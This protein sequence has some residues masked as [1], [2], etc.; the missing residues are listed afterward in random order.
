[1]KIQHSASDS[2]LYVDDYVWYG[3]TET[4]YIDTVQAA[5]GNVIFEDEYSSTTKIRVLWDVNSITDGWME[6]WITLRQK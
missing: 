2:G 6:A 3:N 5:Y 4:D 1:M